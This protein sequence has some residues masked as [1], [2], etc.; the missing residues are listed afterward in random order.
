MWPPGDKHQGTAARTGKTVSLPGA[1]GITME[2]LGAQLVDLNAE[3]LDG[4]AAWLA[5]RKKTID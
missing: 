3:Q 4:V 5:V 1:Q 2:K